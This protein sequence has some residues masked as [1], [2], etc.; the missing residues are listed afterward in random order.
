[1]AMVEILRTAKYWQAGVAH[2][3]GRD[4]VQATLRATATVC[5]HQTASSH[6]DGETEIVQDVSRQK[7]RGCFTHVAMICDDASVQPQLPQNFLGDEHTFAQQVVSAIQPGLPKNIILWRRASAWV[8]KKTM[9]DV[10]HALAAALGEE[11]SARR[12]MLLLDA[13]RIHMGTVFCALVRREGF[14][15]TTCRRS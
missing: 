8:N 2:Q 13:C 4:C 1:M 10:V 9:V 15:C 11:L 5:R 6:P 7:L 14:W 3:F 12:V